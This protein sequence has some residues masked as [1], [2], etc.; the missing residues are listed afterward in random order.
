MFDSGW[1]RG[2]SCGS[3]ATTGSASSTACSSSTIYSSTAGFLRISAMT[4][5]STLLESDDVRRLFPIITEAERLI[6]DPIVRNHGT[7]G[8]SLCPVVF[9]SGQQHLVRFNAVLRAVFDGR[10]D[11]ARRRGDP[12]APPAIGSETR[13]EAFMFSPHRTRLNRQLALR[14]PDP[15]LAQTAAIRGDPSASAR[16]GFTTPR[17]FIATPHTT[18]RPPTRGHPD[19]TRQHLH[20]YRPR[21]HGVDIPMD[22]ERVAFYVPGAQILNKLSDDNYQVDMKVKLGPLTMQYCGRMTVDERDT[23]VHRAVISGKAQETPGQGTTQA[24]VTLVLVE[25]DGVT[26]GTAPHR[27]RRRPSTQ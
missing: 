22:V 11:P 18:R 23:E 27:P 17:P 9:V 1:V 14:D 7:I 4:R 26:Q 10:L 16:H 6:A 13:A 20:R 24:M 2:A 8:G 5:H 12:N 3:P 15:A 25:T 21:R 19:A